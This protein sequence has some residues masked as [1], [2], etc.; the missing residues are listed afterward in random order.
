MVIASTKSIVGRRLRAPA[1][2]QVDKSGGAFAVGSGW[3]YKVLSQDYGFQGL[4]S[5]PSVVTIARE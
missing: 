2:S 4:Q 1:V 5:R 3:H